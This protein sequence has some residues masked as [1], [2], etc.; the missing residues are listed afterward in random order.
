MSFPHAVLVRGL[1]CDGRQEVAD[2]LC[3]AYDRT[4]ER[5]RR[6]S[7]LLPRDGLVPLLADPVSTV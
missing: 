2:Q 6:R 7:D 5:H 4:N 1:R 3:Q